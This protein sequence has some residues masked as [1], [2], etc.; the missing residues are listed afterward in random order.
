MQKKR[1]ASVITKMIWFVL[2]FI[3]G[4]FLWMEHRAHVQEYLP[5]ILF[6]AFLLL[7][8]LMHIFMHHGHSN[9]DKSEQ[10]NSKDNK[11]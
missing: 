7:C 2:L 8:P 6:F 4:Y 11:K 1:S 9:D 5:S 10:K 3:L